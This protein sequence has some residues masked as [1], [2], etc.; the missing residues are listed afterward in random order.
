MRLLEKY[1]REVVIISE[2]NQP[3]LLKKSYPYDLLI[4]NINS[5]TMGEIYKDFQECNS[6]RIIKLIIERIKL[7]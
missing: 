2:R 5:E 1:I 6:I 4:A 7:F 3:N